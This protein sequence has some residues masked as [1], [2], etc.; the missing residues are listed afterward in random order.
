MTKKNRVEIPDEIAAEVLF[1]SNRTCCVCRE[2]KPVQIHHIDENPEN[3]DEDNLAVLCF[4]CHRDTQLRGGF[5]RK[6]DSAQI[7]RYRKDWLIRVANKREQEHGPLDLLLHQKPNQIRVLKLVQIKESSDEHLYSIDTEYPQFTSDNPITEANLNNRIAEFIENVVKD[8]RSAAVAQA[9]EKLRMKESLSVA[10]WDSL[11]IV[12]KISLLTPDY[13]S[14]EF[15][16]QTYGAGA[17]HPNSVT[18]TLNF[19]FAPFVQM[20]LGD[21]FRSSTNYL[22]TL[23]EYCIAAL[24]KLRPL[25]WWNPADRAEQLNR[26]LDDWIT[27]G[28]APKA[29]NYRSFVLMNEGITVFFDPYQVGSYAE[30]RHEVFIPFQYLQ[31]LLTEKLQ[32]NHP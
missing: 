4:D 2:K 8:F 6:L 15:V 20:E 12:H 27:T 22:Q 23:S 7:R 19:Q 25:R 1:R 3:Y 13:L 28:A 17:A 14:I 9:P 10:S 18:R 30:G 29:T 32:R 24:H 11:S 16:F 26:R 5:D 31:P 21:F